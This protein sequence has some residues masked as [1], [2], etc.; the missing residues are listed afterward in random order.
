[1]RTEEELEEFRMSV[2]LRCCEHC[3][4]HE[5]LN[6][7]GFLRGYGETGS[8]VVQRGRRFFCSNRGRRA[9]C[10]RTFSVS[11]AGHLPRFSVLALALWCL[12]REAV[13]T[14]LFRA[15]QLPSWPLS[16]SSAYRLKQLFEREAP[17]FRGW[18][19]QAKGPPET[20][21]REPLSQLLAHF[22]SIL[23]SE[24]ALAEYQLRAQTPL[25][26]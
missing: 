8:E 18:L 17:Q 19:F 4:A 11:F 10:G 5:T 1:V 9:G 25:F 21:S 26:P 23:G 2:K 14:S 24:Q 12:L 7:H 16:L 3:G 15:A 20:Q 13:K 22:A 6:A